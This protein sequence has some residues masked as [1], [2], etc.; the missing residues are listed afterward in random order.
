MIYSMTGFGRGDFENSLMRITVE[1]KSV[2]HRYLDLN[3]RLPRRLNPYESLVRNL[4]KDYVSRGKID[5]FITYEDLSGH[6]TGVC[7][8]RELAAAY[9]GY[10]KEM[11]EDL[12][13]ENNIRG[14]TAI[15]SMP[16]VFTLEEETAEDESIGESLTEALKKACESF[17]EARRREG[18]SLSR[19]LLGKLGE[20][21][22]C[23]EQISERSPQIVAA[24]R[25]RLREKIEELLGDTQIDEARLLTEV[26]IFADKAAVD[27][28]I[29][30]LKTHIRAMEK[31]LTDGGAVGRKLDFIAQ[32]MNREANTTLSKAND[33]TL[34]NIA[35]E[36][37][38]LIEKIRE[39]IQNLE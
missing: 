8:N 21:D 36:L 4:V 32:E 38:T 1:I 33:L 13:I 35:I 5:V 30:R 2:N 24:Y 28:E 10:L 17:C 25:E 23:V 19:D 14:V 27:E 7:Y 11:S 12:G 16:G 26:A 39:Q 3:V 31:E 22:G 37:K 6:D 9:C 15:A 29:V 34:S 20:M 18:D